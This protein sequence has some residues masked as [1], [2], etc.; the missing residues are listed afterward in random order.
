[1]LCLTDCRCDAG[2]PLHLSF[3]GGLKKLEGNISY[4]EFKES[5]TA[6]PD[7]YLAI[8]CGPRLCTLLLLYHHCACV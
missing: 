7:N 2:Y 6:S 5:W 3:A 8:G 4:G 1:M